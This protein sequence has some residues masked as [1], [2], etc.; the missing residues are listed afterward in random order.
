MAEPV[1]D[2]RAEARPDLSVAG[3]RR[4]PEGDQG[5]EAQPTPEG[6]G[7]HLGDAEAD[8]GQ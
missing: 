2:H 5:R 4:L 8:L 3:E 7:V 1:P 6:E